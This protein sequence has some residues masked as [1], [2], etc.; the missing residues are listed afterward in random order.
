MLD[1]TC[2][3]LPVDKPRYLM[4]VGTPGDLLEAIRRGVD[5]FDCVI[6][7]RN[8]R[9]AMAFRGHGS[10]F[11]YATP[12]TSGTSARWKRI[13]PAPRAA[14]VGVICGTCLY[15]ARCSVPYC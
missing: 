7:T 6:P 14:T 10:R 2:P 5:L 15:A 4:G 12:S 3:V 1:A 9:N 8:G 11:D 13:A